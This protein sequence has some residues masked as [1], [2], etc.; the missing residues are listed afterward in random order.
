MATK[1]EAFPSRWISGP[2]IGSNV[3]PVTVDRVTREE[4][5]D[6]LKYV[7]YFHGKTKGLVLNATNWD[8]LEQISG[9]PDSDD[10]HG[11]GCVLVTERVR[12][13][14]GGMID[15]VRIKPKGFS[16]G[17][18][19]KPSPVPNVATELNDEVPF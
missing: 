1:K 7:C 9:L 18:S 5:G 16:N 17:Q 3:V 14:S 13:P 2:D 15:G 4:V 19:K 6:D 10:W 11:V 12:N 8:M